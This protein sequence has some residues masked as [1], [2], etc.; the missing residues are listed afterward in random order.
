M[1]SIAIRKFY[2]ARQFASMKL[3]SAATVLQTAIRKAAALRW[4][5]RLVHGVIKAQARWR[6][7]LARRIYRELRIEVCFF[8]FFFFCF[9]LFLLLMVL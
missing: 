8:F 9:V 4:R 2:A 7:L 6:A 5:S 1:Y 3:E